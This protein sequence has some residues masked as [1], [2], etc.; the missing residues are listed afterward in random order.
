MFVPWAS[1]S[2]HKCIMSSIIFQDAFHGHLIRGQ[3]YIYD[4][5]VCHKIYF[6]EFKKRNFVMHFI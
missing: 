5:Y 2:H 4:K 6:F 1:L 3:L